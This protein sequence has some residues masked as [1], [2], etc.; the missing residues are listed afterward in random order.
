MPT[1]DG[2]VMVWHVPNGKNMDQF[3]GDARWKYS[4]TNRFLTGYSNSFAKVYERYPPRSMTKGRCSKGPSIPVTMR[5]GSW[6]D[7]RNN[8]A[9]NSM[10]E[11]STGYIHFSV[12]NWERGCNPFCP[13]VRY[14]GCNTEHACIGTGGYMPEGN[15]RQCS[16]FS[17]WDWD[18]RNAR[19]GWSASRTMTE[20]AVFIFTR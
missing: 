9:P 10:N 2:N 14:N 11:A 3:A 7:F 19:R 6:S 16:D 4:T 12:F 13:G 1:T 8:G 17:G 20:S 18:G 5:K 15:P